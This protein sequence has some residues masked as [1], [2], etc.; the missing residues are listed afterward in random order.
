MAWLTNRP[1]GLTYSDERAYPGHT[2]FC[3]VSGHHATMIDMQGQIV[4]QWH[5]DEG[6]QHLKLLENGNL[7]I[8]TSPL[9]DAGGREN[10]GGSAG[11]ADG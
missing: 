6:I 1:I 3:S 11:A 4:H 7:L 5:H 9:E 8:Q 2:I 10:S